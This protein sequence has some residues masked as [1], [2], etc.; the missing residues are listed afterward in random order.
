LTALPQVRGAGRA[1]LFAQ[2]RVG[3]EFLSR[4]LADTP[5]EAPLFSAAR[6]LL[7]PELSAVFWVP[8]VGEDSETESMAR[9]KKAQSEEDRWLFAGAVAGTRDPALARQVMELSLQADLPNTVAPWLPGM[10]GD[11]PAHAAMAYAFVIDHWSSLAEKTGGMFGARAWLL[12]SASEGFSDH[13]AARRLLVDQQQVVGGP[14]AAAAA[15]AAAQIDL[16]SEIRARESERLRMAL[17]AM[18]GRLGV[19]P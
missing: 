2:A 17:Q 19:R 8:R 15:Q 4:A 16:R 3:L 1:A 5:A 18:P 6:A 9:L 14:G 10:V 12:P 7:A 11:E 13:A